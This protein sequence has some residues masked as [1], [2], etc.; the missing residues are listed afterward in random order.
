MKTNGLTRRL[1]QRRE[2][3]RLAV[4]VCVA[5]FVVHS[6]FHFLIFIHSVLNS[7]YFIM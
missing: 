3:K 2:T 4:C 1:E 7:L 6:L 5:D